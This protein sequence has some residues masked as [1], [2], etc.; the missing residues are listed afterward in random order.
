[1]ARNYTIHHIDDANL[2][3]AL[4]KEGLTYAVIAEKME[5]PPST[6][7]EICNTSGDMGRPGIDADYRKAYAFHS[8]EV[9]AKC[10]ELRKTGM[11]FRAIA[12]QVG[13]S[14]GSAWKLCNRQK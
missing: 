14:P 9:A 7:W 10:K 2:C 3:R 11:T 12:Q 1:M 13:V 4:R 5:M 8:D 6:V